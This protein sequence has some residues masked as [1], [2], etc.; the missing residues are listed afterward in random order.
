[1]KVSKTGF[2]K[3]AY[4]DVLS[5]TNRGVLA[6]YLVAVALGVDRKYRQAWDSWDLE[7]RGA[8]IEVKSTA[9]VQAWVY[10]PSKPAFSIKPT[11]TW[12]RTKGL[13]KTSAYNADVYVLAF[14]FVADRNKVDPLDSDQWRFW[15]LGK[16]R[17]EV[18]FGKGARV[19]VERLVEREKLSGC[20]YRE[21]RK[22][23]QGLSESETGWRAGR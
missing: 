14:L 4:S 17:I 5:N 1:M 9:A 7:Y 15:V 11:K 16:S 19:T 18:I 12:D 20:G 21:I 6:E 23:I 13:G 3:W 22:Q 8:K 2:W 10:G